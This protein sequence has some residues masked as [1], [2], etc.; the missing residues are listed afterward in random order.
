VCRHVEERFP[1][2]RAEISSLYPRDAVFRDLCRD[3]GVCAE[4]LERVTGL[5]PETR[6][7]WA[8]QFGELLAELEVEVV[9]YLNSSTI[10]P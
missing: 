6:T 8:G 10:W 4:M 5:P 2:R 7:Q 3:Y 9:E 1:D